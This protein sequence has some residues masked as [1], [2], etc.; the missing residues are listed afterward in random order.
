[1]GKGKLVFK[2]DKPKKKK[3]KSKHSS[4]SLGASNQDG[5]LASIASPTHSGN[6]ESSLQ[7]TRECTQ[8]SRDAPLEGPVIR[9]GKG[10]L[11]SSG[12]VLMG[13]GTNFNS[14]LTAGDA[15]V[16]Q[17]PSDD[18]AREEM[19]VVTMRLSDT[20]ASISSSFSCDLKHPTD[21]QYISKPKNRQREKDENEKNMRV[22][23]EEI[24]RSAFGTYRSGDG[25]TQ[26]LVY[27]ERT[28]HGS[29][30]IRRETI[31]GR[32]C[33]RSNLLE[34]RTQKKSDKYC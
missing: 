10:K 6:S 20:S 34:M 17:I 30:M 24:E 23:K 15:I 32:N 7:Q 12:T 21:F 27:R 1:M 11:T 9:Q 14:N 28:E 4:S 18:G 2:G 26:E 33:T 8:R 19:R 25:N 22:T 13:H 29:Y 3:K 16:V 31:D 5:N